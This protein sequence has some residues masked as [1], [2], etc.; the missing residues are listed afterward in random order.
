MDASAPRQRAVSGAGHVAVAAV[1]V[2]VASV[3]AAGALAGCGAEP[4]PAPL[5]PLPPPAAVDTAR[6]AD[7]ARCAQCHT[8]GDTALRDAAGRDVSPV[9]RWRPSMMAL[10][11]RDPMYLAVWSADRAAAADPA[12]VDALCVR[13][14]APAGAEEAAEHGGALGF[15]DLVAAT[16]AAAAIGR[17]GVTCTACHQIGA[18]GLGSEA[19]LSGGFRIGFERTLWGPIAAPLTGPMAMF[20]RYTP[21]YG[22]HLLDSALCGTC[23]VVLVP[24]PGGGELVEQATYLEWRSS[25]FAA[26]PVTSCAACHLPTVDEDGATLATAIARFPED[27]GPRRLGRHEL[28]GGNA[29]MLRR[30]AGAVDWL[31]AGVTADELLAAADRTERFL[32][33]AATVRVARAAREG[34]ELVIDVAVEN[35]TGH[36]LPTGY[37]TRRVWLEL[38]VRAG[39]AVVFHSG[40]VDARGA[41]VGAAGMRP[42]HDEI[43]S[44]DEVQVYE[45]VFVDGAGRP[46]ARALEARDVIKDNR[47]LPAGW[48]PAPS[49]AGR[50]AIIGVARDP[51]FAAG[52]DTVTYRVVGAPA[53]ALTVTATLWYAPVAPAVVDELAAIATPAG[54]RFAAV[55]GDGAVPPT[56]LA[57]ETATVP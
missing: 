39:D 35:H 10:A 37:P 15:D 5:A 25:S 16:H 36:K 34:G 12:A 52:G 21:A 32:A 11:A 44:A 18:A 17:E 54:A 19:S 50:V 22:A 28:V 41:L 7:A 46:T 14:H 4:P 6:F 13:C 23:H 45:A 47:L 53:A 40:A 20:V 29:W 51:D 24:L 33:R 43:T 2:A 30:L 9:A 42:H 31:G 38:V 56:R 26:P 27:L 3:V 48:A 49:D 8:A 57:T 55:T 1:A